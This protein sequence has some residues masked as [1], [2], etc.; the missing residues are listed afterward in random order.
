M[1]I[2]LGQKII[3]KI[4]RKKEKHPEYKFFIPELGKTLPSDTEI[5]ITDEYVEICGIK[6]IP[7][8]SYNGVAEC[9]GRHDYKFGGIKDC[10]FIDVG[11]NI[12]DSAL[13]AATQ[14]HIQKI[15]AY[16][17]FPKTYNILKQNIE[18]NPQY[19]SKIEIFNYGWSNQ[20]NE[21]STSFSD[22]FTEINSVH[23]WF[24]DTMF[25]GNNLFDYNNTTKIQIRTSSEIL[26]DIIAQNPNQKIV[27]KLDVEG[28]EYEIIEDLNK[29]GLLKS[30]DLIIMEWHYRGYESLT[31]ILEKNGFIW[32]NHRIM[33]N[34]GILRAVRNNK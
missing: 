13:F 4:R 9:F 7:I 1:H 10:I 14:E 29:S 5:N 21:L 20:N 33:D 24:Y 2:E 28:S 27:L 8:D 23:K 12:G 34:V 32:F 3:D 18:L 31:E 11:A 6:Y 26:S 22:N 17:P 16:E 25:G 15:Y 19:S 30:V